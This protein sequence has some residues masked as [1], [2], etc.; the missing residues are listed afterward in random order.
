MN[1]LYT[2]HNQ[3]CT[4][5]GICEDICPRKSIEIKIVD[6]EYRPVLNEDTCLGDKCGRCIKVCPGAN[7]NL[8]DQVAQLFPT[9][10]NYNEFIGRYVSLYT[11]YSADYDI[12]YHGASGGMVSQ[13]LIFLLDKKII[14][15]AVITAY[16][17][18]N[19]LCPKP[20]IARSKAE[21]ISSRS[22]KY[23]PVSMNDIGNQITSN[24]GRYIIVG[25]PCHIQGFRKRAEID[26]KFKES[27]L[28]YFAIY[29]SS[30]RSFL[31]QDFLLDKF[32]IN[33]SDIGSFTYRDNGCLG[34]MVIKNSNN[35]IELDIPF[36]KYYPLLRSFFKPK[37]CL[38]CIDHFGDLADVSFGDIHIKPYSDDHI[39]INSIIV[40]NLHFDRLL[41]K[42]QDGAY[43]KI[44]QLEADVLCKS[45]AAMLYS[46]K[47]RVKAEM[48][49]Q[50]S[51]GYKPVEYCGELDNVNPF[52]K[53]Y[54]H[55]CIANIQRFIGHHKLLWPLINL[56]N[57]T[58]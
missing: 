49:I 8:K 19:K 38:Q 57:I 46:K 6:G 31:A 13:F 7:I 56:S 47:R 35:H 11:G 5:C 43:I 28:G 4:G 26:K 30:N 16:D 12:R 3:L 33:K 21:V 36:I 10:S 24:K 40:R 37:R 15:G 20:F 54:I 29:C 1:I 45:Q 32:G 44:N 22:S 34:N 17:A 48:K 52:I 39:G 50:K 42:A 58:K 9:T 14:D 51:F 23:C 18:F 27:I 25:L 2:L 55:Q 53:D 41:K